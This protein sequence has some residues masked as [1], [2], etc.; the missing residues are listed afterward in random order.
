MQ[1]EKKTK[2]QLILELRELRKQVSRLQSCAEDGER[3]EDGPAKSEGWL[4]QLAENI[5][6]VFW[7]TDREGTELLYVSPAYE[8]VWGRPRES[9]YNDPSSW[10]RGVHP[11]DRDRVKSA[12]SRSIHGDSDIEY[13]IVRP[14]GTE[15]TVRNRVFPIRDDEGQVYRLAGVAQDITDR[16]QAEQRLRLLSSAVEQST[17]GIALSDLDGN[18][19]FVNDAFAAMHGYTPEKLI[20]NH[21]SIFHTPDQ[22]PSV[23][24]ANRQTKEMG[25]FSGE[26]WH[27]RRDGSTFPAL[28]HNSL[29]RNESGEIAGMMGTL[30]DITELKRMEESLRESEE[31]HRTVVEQ[32]LQGTLIVQHPPF[33]LS[34]ANRGLAKLLG[35]TVEELMSMPPQ[36]AERLVH[37][38]DRAILF[39]QFGQWLQKKPTRSR[40][41]LRVMRKDKAVR[42]MEVSVGRAEYRGQSSIQATFLDITDRKA[43][44]EA[45]RQSEAQYR[46]TIDS[47]GD[48]IHVV[49]TE[50]SV[51]L[52]N[53]AFREWLEE[54]GMDLEGIGQKLFDVFPFLP[55]R[56]RQEYEEVFRTGQTLLTE[57]STTVAGK[58]YVTE[59]RKIPIFERG[60]V[61]RI[62][63]AIRDI[64]ES[65]RAEE[66][67]RE[68]GE[69]YRALFEQAADTIVVVDVQTGEIV[70]FNR[71]AHENLGYTEQEFK[72]LKIADFDVFESEEEV[73]R[74]LEQIVRTGS[75]TFETKHRRR[76]GEIRDIEVTSKAIFVRERDF[77]QSI[78]RDITDRNR[79]K[80]ALAAEKERLAVT[81]QSIAEGVIATDHKGR[82]SLLNTVAT[83]LT[84]WTQDEAVNKPLS[85]FLVIVDENTG[86]HRQN[87]V[88][89]V[90]KSNLTVE[91]SSDTLLLS[92]D[93]TER[94]IAYTASP[95][96]DE[97]G[98][99]IGVVLVFR[100]VT[101]LRRM[102]EEVLNARRIESLGVLAG[103]IA[104]DFNN[105][106]TA[107]TGN[108]FLAKSRSQGDR[109]MLELLMGAEKA[110]FQAKRLTRQ[111][112]TFSKG[113]LP[114]KETASLPELLEE[115]A[116]FALSGSN[117]KCEFS[118]PQNLWPV[119]V[120]VSQIGQVVNNLIINAAQAM[121]GGG[122]I[123]VSARNVD[124]QEKRPHI[125]KQGRYVGISIQD[126]GV[127]ISK[128]H[129]GRIFDPYF[130]TKPEG[131][132]LGL[133]TAHT[134]V[135]RHS[136]H[137]S[138][139]SK[140]GV[141]TTF[142]V[143]LPASVG[144]VR[145]KRQGPEEPIHGKGRVLLMDDEKEI[146][147]TTG[148][149]LRHLGYE[150]DVAREGAEAVSLFIAARNSRQP[151]DAVI[152]DLTVAGGMGGKEAM[153]KLLE[154]DPNVKALVS[155]GYSNDPIMANYRK[156]GFHDFITKPYKGEEL[157]K[158]LHNVLRGAGGDRVAPFIERQ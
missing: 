72:K 113:G 16:K 7:M 54:R 134:I 75:S 141:G 114:I 103:G 79:A 43:A 150:V 89:E 99:M 153:S 145:E 94:M 128:E 32:S 44:E 8:E 17:E 73:A 156:H 129:F 107:A 112:L 127:G 9:V 96:R 24:A 133:A 104:H 38:E 70:E 123:K 1:D 137:I 131:T 105:T 6:Q 84:G 130:T 40:L 115:S 88:E 154:I 65:K 30:R 5:P 39:A 19:L 140:T 31:K 83:E 57:E 149:V 60:E 144:P 14:D 74:H 91:M 118:I 136:G 26:I 66:A 125:L 101:V 25:H 55:E 124:E 111:L 158:K 109:E 151:Y 146:R 37:P 119:E 148:H 80:E 135:S 2:K 93:G 68:S 41:E 29:L 121:P 21:L 63:T 142:H 106:L 58:T 76:T 15:R 100:D 12:M 35:Y 13:R 46:T 120:D 34:F 126:S 59:T 132:G 90:L 48:L 45:L 49:D 22:A 36:E 98:T 53:R 152:L 78:W 56:V 122:V 23:E 147:D 81:L 52:F 116:E 110:V 102:E 143:Y 108:L 50:L 82:V 139:E 64:T 155:S 28:M 97:Q 20:G 61:T 71:K 10:L 85:N 95:M 67:L 33:R 51:L 69:R 47:L 117:V 87:P 62:V 157:S 11:E 18:L 4:R 42:W 92:R 138:F 27:A 86:E 3:W 77:V